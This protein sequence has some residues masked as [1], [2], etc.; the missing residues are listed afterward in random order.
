MTDKPESGITFFPEYSSASTVLPF[1][2][3][4]QQILETLGHRRAPKTPLSGASP[5]LAPSANPISLC[6]STAVLACSVLAT[7]PADRCRI[8]AACS[9][10]NVSASATLVRTTSGHMRPGPLSL[11][12][13]AKVS[14]LRR[15]VSKLSSTRGWALSLEFL[16]PKHSAN[17]IIDPHLA[18]NLAPCAWSD[19][20][21]QKNVG[22]DDKELPHNP[23]RSGSKR[24]RSPFPRPSTDEWRSKTVLS[25]DGGGIRGCGSRFT[26][27]GFIEGYRSLVI[28][29]ALMEEVCRVER[30]F[31]VEATSSVCASALGSLDYGEMSVAD[32]T[33]G[34]PV[35]RGRPCHYFDYVAGAGTGG[36]VAV[37]LGRYRM[38]VDDAMTTY[39]DICTD[40]SLAGQHLSYTNPF[41]SAARDPAGKCLKTHFKKL[42]PARASPNEDGRSLRSDPERCHTVV[43]GCGPALKTLRSDD[44]VSTTPPL[45][46]K[47]VLS[48]CF[49]PAEPPSRES[50]CAAKHY[51]ANPSRTVLLEVSRTLK[52]KR[53]GALLLDDDDDDDDD[54]VQGSEEE[55][56]SVSGEEEGIAIDLLSVGAAIDDDGF[57]APHT[58]RPVAHDDSIAR[59]LYSQMAKQIR[60][61]HKDL[62][63]RCHRF[64]ARR[65]VLRL[66]G[67][68]DGVATLPLAAIPTSIIEDSSSSGS[69]APQSIIPPAK[70][71]KLKPKTDTPAALERIDQTTAFLF[72]RDGHGAAKLRD[73]AS[74]LVRK[75]RGRAEKGGK[76]GE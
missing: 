64:D 73:W 67:R 59:F 63:E 74:R 65:D 52:E 24:P 2:K 69:S 29:R 18:S 57:T 12:C 36:V 33:D 26:L 45:S 10:C 5:L 48:Q 28:L 72:G 49:S 1:R 75:R 70:H 53:D 22:F 3:I 32:V 14:D 42:V 20:T 21:D 39:R 9:R 4:V 35:F 54:A 37:M 16:T 41:L 34:M 15:E 66:Y 71:R 44:V 13:F 76:S 62:E 38:S 47:H 23:S 30:E 25:I 8:D 7:P 46:I 55:E 56:D 17:H 19:M 6:G 11:I 27:Q 50:Y 61:V 58:A 43:C 31:D 51:H 68:L 60:T 40:I